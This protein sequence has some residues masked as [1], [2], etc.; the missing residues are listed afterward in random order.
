ME[1][2]QRDPAVTR[3]RTG[4]AGRVGC[5]VRLGDAAI[6]ATHIVVAW[7]QLTR[8]NYVEHYGLLRAKLPNGEYETPKPH[9]SWNAKH[10][11]T[12]LVLFQLER[13]NDHHPNAARRY[14]ALRHFPDLP[15]LPSV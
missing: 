11:Y 13:Q 7:W 15:Q 3:R 10:V 14:Q 12:N 1:R 9:H 8:A 2:A 4:A 6:L 5:S